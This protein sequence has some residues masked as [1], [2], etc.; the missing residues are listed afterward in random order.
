MGFGK[1]LLKYLR[2]AG[3]VR[4]VSIEAASDSMFSTLGMRV[5]DAWILAWRMIHV[6]SRRRGP[7]A[8]VVLILPRL[9]QLSTAVL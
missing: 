7:M 8:V 3:P 6:D 9:A 4:C 1:V 2:N 5:M